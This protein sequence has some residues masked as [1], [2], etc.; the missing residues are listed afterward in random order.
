MKKNLNFLGDLASKFD[1]DVF[2][3]ALEEA[4]VK[5][6]NVKW[7][8]DFRQ[9]VQNH[10]AHKSTSAHRLKVTIVTS[11]NRPWSP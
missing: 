10:P 8:R 3:Y 5:V 7:V 1:Q 2:D 9:D 4:F 11:D 6:A